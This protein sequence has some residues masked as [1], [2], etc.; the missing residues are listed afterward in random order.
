M[1]GTDLSLVG[2]AVLG[3]IAIG[4]LHLSDKVAKRC[5]DHEGLVQRVVLSTRSG[6]YR[7]VGREVFTVTLP[8]LGARVAKGAKRTRC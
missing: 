5:A 6:R 4:K 1:T 3:R 8:R 7:Y 2:V